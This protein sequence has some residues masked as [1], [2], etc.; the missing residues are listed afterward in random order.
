MIE[1]ADRGLQPF[2]CLKLKCVTVHNCETIRNVGLTYGILIYSVIF[3]SFCKLTILM[4]V[5]RNCVCMNMNMYHSS[6]CIEEF[7]PFSIH[8][9]AQ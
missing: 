2:I 9:V 3:Y 7:Q 1:E 5:H 8:V 4:Y 6:T